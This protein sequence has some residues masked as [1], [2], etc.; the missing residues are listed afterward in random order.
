MAKERLEE[1]AVDIKDQSTYP[2][3][4]GGE[5]ADHPTRILLFC[6]HNSL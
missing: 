1:I 2:L 6:F 4:W 5:R 3:F